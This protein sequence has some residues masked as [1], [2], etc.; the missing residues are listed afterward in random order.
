[1]LVNQP[2]MLAHLRRGQHILE[3][4]MDECQCTVSYAGCLI[5]RM[6]QAGCTNTVLEYGIAG[7][8]AVHEKQPL[9]IRPDGIG[10][11]FEPHR[12]GRAPDCAQ[13]ARQGR[14]GLELQRY[15]PGTAH[16]LAQCGVSRLQGV[17]PVTVTIRGQRR[18]RDHALLHQRKRS[19]GVLPDCGRFALVRAARIEKSHLLLQHI[20]IARGDEIL[21]EDHERPEKNIAVR[22]P[23]TDAAFAFEEHEPLRPIA[24]GILRGHHTQQ[25]V[26]N[27]RHAAEC[28]QHLDRPLTHIAR[29]PAAAGE[30]FQ[31]PRRQ[32]MHQRVV[33]I[34][35]HDIGHP[36]QRRRQRARRG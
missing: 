22:I 16:V 24:V 10:P 17:V 28:K 1:M 5:A 36:S 33:R 11:A 20:A 30:L 26:A 29:A 35:R 13:R 18:A 27:R 19:L 31:A 21:A 12:I 15:G 32:V 34:P 7:Q 4:R 14:Q 9:K 3:N 8:H 2:Q 6:Q 25:Q 23:G